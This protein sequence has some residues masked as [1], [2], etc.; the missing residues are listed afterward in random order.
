MFIY[1]IRCGKV[2]GSIRAKSPGHAFRRIMKLGKM[3][4]S[5][6]AKLA[7][8]RVWDGT[9]REF[10]WIYQD[11]ESLYSDGAAQRGRG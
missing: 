8:Y 3:N 4:R 10:V 7:R 2:V 11:P 6:W 5:Q 1:E 9:A